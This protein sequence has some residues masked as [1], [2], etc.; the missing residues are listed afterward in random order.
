MNEQRLRRLVGLSFILG[1]LLINVPYAILIASF[2]YPAI[3]RE[4]TAVILERFHAGG[5]AL[6][7]TWL[8]FAWVGLPLLFA[9]GMLPRLL[10]RADIPYLG[11]ATAV[12]IAGMVVQM[13]GLLRWVFVVP[14]LAEM[15][16]DPS[17]TESTRAAVS[18]VFLALHQYG[19]V[20]V[21]E[22]LGYAF[23]CIWMALVSLGLLRSRSLPRWVGV[24]GLGAAALYSLAH[25][26][27]LA[28]V[29]PGFLA[30]ELAGLLGSLCWL[31]WMIVLG[32]FLLRAAPELAPRP[33]T[34]P[35]AAP[36]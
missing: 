35:A 9:I 32:I 2:D 4:P 21:G 7:Y 15:Y 1:A 16:V 23:V 17:S 11:I 28:T 12:G 20:V 19:G 27:L 8:A 34:Q 33:T 31:A 5:P 24:F 6:I 36:A 10:A 14:L 18:V 25:G 26:E 30:W 3:L 22:H 29:I 13:V